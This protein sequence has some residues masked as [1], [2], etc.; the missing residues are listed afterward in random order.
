MLKS[1]LLLTLTMCLV[2][3]AVPLASP[4]VHAGPVER[5]PVVQV[6]IAPPTPPAAVAPLEPAFDE[7]TAAMKIQFQSAQHL[8]Y[9]TT[10]QLRHS[11]IVN[12]QRC[13]NEPGLG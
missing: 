6:S 12:E 1:A 7:A 5:T 10:K 3:L 2:G 13:D 11:D 9:A 4:N 8:Q